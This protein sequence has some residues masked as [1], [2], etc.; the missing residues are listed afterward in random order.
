MRWGDLRVEERGH[1]STPGI[2]TVDLYDLA[3]DGVILAP[4]SEART[5]W[6]KKPSSEALHREGERVQAER[7]SDAKAKAWAQDFASCF[8]GAAKSPANAIDPKVAEAFAHLGLPTTAT[9][10][11]IRAVQK[12]RAKTEHPDKGGSHEASSRTNQAADVAE[13]WAR[14]FGGEAA[15]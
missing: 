13:Q 3:R 12:Q 4:R 14:Q 9:V 8:A 2:W 15:E 10:D 6:W 5:V 11:E 1:R 7:A